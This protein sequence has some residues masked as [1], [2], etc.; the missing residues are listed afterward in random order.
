MDPAVI[1]LLLRPRQR[2]ARAHHPPQDVGQAAPDLGD[3]SVEAALG[4]QL[5]GGR[6]V[7][8]PAAIDPRRP[9]HRHARR[10]AGPLP[11]GAQ[12]L[13]RLELPF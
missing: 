5:R 6:I 8:R 11:I 4:R 7:A 13:S 1:I 2:L 12:S 9:A 3:G 10:Q